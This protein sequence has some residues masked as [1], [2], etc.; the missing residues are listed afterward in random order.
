MAELGWAGAGLG[1][2]WAG[3]GRGWGVGGWGGGKAHCRGA[4]PRKNWYA[5]AVRSLIWSLGLFRREFNMED[6][7]MDCPWWLVFT[8]SPVK[9]SASLFITVPCVE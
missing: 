3:L 7:M 5:V 2:G 4:Y 8:V 1:L 9:R 6:W